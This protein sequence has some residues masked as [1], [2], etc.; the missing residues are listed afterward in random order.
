MNT[1]DRFY[2]RLPLENPAYQM[3]CKFYGKKTAKRSKVPLINHIEEGLNV[4]ARRKTSA[5][6][7]AAYCLHP[8]VQSDEALACFL[9]PKGDSPAWDFRSMAISYRSIVLA[10]EYRRVANSYLS[11]DLPSSLVQSPISDVWEMLLA[12]KIQNRDDFHRYHHATHPRSKELTEYFEN[13]M[14]IL[15]AKLGITDDDI[16]ELTRSLKNSTP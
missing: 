8:I 12:D 3:I 9:S 15:K 6:A 1:Q 11:K 10:M 13:W 2:H 16:N 7:Q 5:L 4:M 14:N